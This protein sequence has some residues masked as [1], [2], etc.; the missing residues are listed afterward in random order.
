MLVLACV[1]VLAQFDRCHMDTR[2]SELGLLG[3]SGLAWEQ[4]PAVETFTPHPTQT[5]WLT[6]HACLL[7]SPL[8]Y[9]FF[10]VLLSTDSPFRT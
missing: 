7:L 2:R 1:C 6:P 4:R 8:Y 5:G 9:H 10:H 3:T